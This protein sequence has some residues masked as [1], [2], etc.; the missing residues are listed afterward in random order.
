MRFVS[1]FVGSI[2]LWVFVL[3]IA[4]AESDLRECF[5]LAGKRY[6]IDPLLIYSIAKNESNFDPFAI[7]VNQNGSKDIG[8]MQIN[9]T[10]FPLLSKNGIKE[11][12]LVDPC[13]NIEVGAWILAKAI[14]ENGNNWRAVGAYNAGSTSGVRREKN[15]IKYA[16]SIFIYYVALRMQ[17]ST[18][19]KRPNG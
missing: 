15:R 3:S 4:Y 5:K 13:N 6:E 11:S 10:W 7:N 2:S 8:I 9:S 14:A 19:E 16:K 18:D 12:D 1:C 17:L